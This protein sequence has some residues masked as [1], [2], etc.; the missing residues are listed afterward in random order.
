MTVIELKEKLNQFP[1]DFMVMIPNVDWNPYSNKPHDV[2]VLN[3][4]R[5]CNEADKCVFID[6]Y[7]EDW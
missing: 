4:T 7:E 1:N 2:P 6:G 5:G 3:V